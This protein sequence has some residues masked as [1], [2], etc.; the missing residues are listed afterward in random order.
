MTSKASNGAHPFRFGHP[1][2]KGDIPDHA[3][4]EGI[5]DVQFLAKRRWKDGSVK[6]GI[7]YGVTEFR[8]GEQRDFRIVPA[9]PARGTPLTARSIVTA[10]PSATFEASPLGSVTLGDLLSKPRSIWAAGTQAIH[11]AYY[12]KVEDQL[13]A[14]FYVTLFRDGR[15][16]VRVQ[17][18]NAAL[19]EWKHK[20][21]KPTITIGE[22]VVYSKADA[23][24]SH[25]PSRE[26]AAEAWIGEDPQI[27]Y[28]FDTDYL[29]QTKVFPNLRP[30]RAKASEKVLNGLAQQY[31]PFGK[32]GFT[33]GMS[34]PGHHNEMG[35]LPQWDALF[36]TTGDQRAYRSVITHANA[37]LSYGIGLAR[38]KDTRRAITPLD[39]PDSGWKGGTRD[40]G[41]S[42]NMGKP[43]EYDIA[44]CP[45]AGYTAYILTGDPWH[46]DTMEITSAWHW[47]CSPPTHGRGTKRQFLRQV[48][49]HAWSIRCVGQM[50][51]ICPDGDRWYDSY[52][53]L[54]AFQFRKMREYFNTA[55]SSE[56]GLPFVMSAYKA[57]GKNPLWFVTFMHDFMIWTFHHLDEA[58]VRFNSEADEA[59]FKYVADKVCLAIVGQLGG[60][61]GDQYCFARATDYIVQMSDEVGVQFKMYL[62][63]DLYSDWKTVMEKSRPNQ[64][65]PAELQ[66]EGYLTSAQTNYWGYKRQSIE[67]AV[68][69]NTEG[70][71]EARARLRGA[72]NYRL[73]ENS[74][75]ADS[76]QFSA[77][78]RG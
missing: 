7:F 41:S 52:R 59:A 63:R 53:D 61:E 48:R 73:I 50:L 35:V 15:M 20:T 11:A 78:A 19:G 32:A 40:R 64:S 47:A 51:A 38:H 67:I 6:H 28:D 27:E 58:E 9:A 13:G 68:D 22:Q 39:Y 14:W 74:P 36:L 5:A 65:C 10:R 2:A 60:K 3:T 12:G 55:P 31:T 46:L 1:F 25:Q 57:N 54:L 26:Y 71:R 8:R 4:L 29:R 21:Y 56:L 16:H 72:S 17:V 76:P 33:A 37:I 23:A 45:S 43:L 66:K 24:M 30:P 77:V 42:G 49:Q 44:H 62:P 75:W 34:A 18:I 69:R 70:A